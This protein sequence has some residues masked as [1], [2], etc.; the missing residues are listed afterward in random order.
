[1]NPEEIKKRLARGRE[2]EHLERPVVAPTSSPGA[3]EVRITATTPEQGD[4]FSLIE[5]LKGEWKTDEQGWNLIA[6]PFKDLSAPGD[7]RLLMNQY[8]E[9][10][11]FG[12]TDKGV[13]NRGIDPDASGDT[14]QL[15]DAIDYMQ[16]I[17]EV[18]SDDFPPSML[19]ANKGEGLHHEPGLFLQILN[20]QS[21][22][23]QGKGKS[24]GPKLEVARLGTIPHG[25][26]VLAMGTVEIIDG[27]PIIPDLNAL[28]LKTTQDINSAYLTPY[29]HYEDNPFFGEVP[30]STPGFP[31]FFS[32]NANAI[33]QFA[34]DDFKGRVKKTTVLHFDTKFGKGGIVNIPFIVK[35]ADATEM[36]ATFW[37]MELE[38]ADGSAPEFVM[39][40]SQTVFLD[41]FDSTTETGK[42]VRWPHVSINTLRKS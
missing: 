42:R 10:L 36:V 15:I 6:L 24:Q 18:D 37:I 23:G 28:P 25:D 35:Q 21:S 8:G 11:N 1:M 19:R 40:Y 39:Q 3:P 9:T 26:S 7:Y 5:T 41:F 34:L 16:L 17:D 13:P 32:T 4:S 22:V 27:P 31:G 33:L 30:Q 2:I 29:K 20:H 14:T 38:S 12:L